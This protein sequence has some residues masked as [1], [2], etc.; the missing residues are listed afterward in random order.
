MG[1]YVFITTEEGFPPDFPIKFV[2][3]VNFFIFPMGEHLGN[4]FWEY[5]RS[6]GSQSLISLGREVEM[7]LR[8]SWC[9]FQMRYL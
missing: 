4:V 6:F 9:H 3:K 1:F 7:I 5:F 2:Q 8:R